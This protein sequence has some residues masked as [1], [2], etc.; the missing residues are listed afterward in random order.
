[1]G[2][3]EAFNLKGIGCW[4]WSQDHRPPHF[5]AKRKGQWEIRVYFLLPKEQM[6]ERV[7]G[8]REAITRQ[9]RNALCD[10]AEL[11]REELLV[12]WERKVVCDD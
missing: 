1:M 8:A 4:F 2:K 6:L 3:L 5:H 11:Y 7:R 10:M 12:E 9:D